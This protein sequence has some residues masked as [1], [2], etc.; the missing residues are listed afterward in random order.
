MVFDH[1]HHWPFMDPVMPGGKPAAVLSMFSRESRVA[2]SLKTVLASRA[3]YFNLDKI[4][5]GRNDDLRRE[6]QRGDDSPGSDRTII[7][8]QDTALQVIIKDT[9]DS[10]DQVRCR[11][12]TFARRQPPAVF[13]VAF[14]LERV[15][16]CI[17]LLHMRGTTS[18]FEVIRSVLTHEVVLD[19]S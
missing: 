16:Y 10:I 18:V 4:L 9:L 1:Q 2:S 17:L 15:V 19:S 7:G 11:T 8:T 5:N 12:R 6:R 14:E 3:T 13:T